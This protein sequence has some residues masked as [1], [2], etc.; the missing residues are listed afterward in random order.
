[1]EVADEL[2][3]AQDTLYAIEQ[4]RIAA[5][6][7]ARAEAEA[8]AAAAEAE[9]AAGDQGATPPAAAVAPPKKV[10][11][12]GTARQSLTGETIHGTVETSSAQEEMSYVINLPRV[13]TSIY[14]MLDAQVDPLVTFT[15][16]RSETAGF[17]RSSGT[18]RTSSAATTFLAAEIKRY[19][20]TSQIQHFSTK[21][22]TLVTLRAGEE[23][24]VNQLPTLIPERIAN[25]HEVTRATIELT[26]ERQK[27]PDSPD[28]I[29][30]AQVTEPIWLLAKSSAPQAVRDPA[31]GGW[32][33]LTR[34][35]GAFVTPNSP[36]VIGFLRTALEK[37]PN[38]RFDGYQSNVRSQAAAI[39]GALQQEG[40]AY[41]D[42]VIDFNPSEN[43][44]SQTRPH[45]QRKLDRSHGQLYRRR[46]ALCQSAPGNF[47]QPG[48]YRLAASCDCGLGDRAR[49]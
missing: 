5:E 26:I 19:R 9:Q 12:G 41:V 2:L 7:Q 38:K 15:L 13:P 28:W 22:T 6:A 31:T 37:H 46:I 8:Q 35:L 33:D 11:R 49:Q 39:Y 45:T 14:G 29:M 43:A 27:D 36:Q 40:I 17:L 3:Q 47:R 25:L 4:A 32:N 42:S 16:R 18:R 48:D 24:T 21:S 34:F 10:F 23:E 30:E 20:V 44:Q 1:M